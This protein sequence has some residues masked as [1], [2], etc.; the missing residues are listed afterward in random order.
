MARIPFCSG[1]LKILI[2]LSCAGLHR[3]T[4]LSD[5]A[6]RNLVE[7]NKC[8]YLQISWLSAHQD[9]CK[10]VWKHD[11]LCLVALKQMIQQ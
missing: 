5:C 4:R 7:I 11:S 8:G 9:L 3:Y 2:K 10:L 1:E 6:A